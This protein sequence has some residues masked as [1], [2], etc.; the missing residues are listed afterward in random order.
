MEIGMR[1][2]MLR[3]EHDWKKTELARQLGISH[4]QVSR[5]ESGETETLSSDILIR[6][7]EVFDVST[8]YLLGLT[9]IKA[10]K[11]LDVVKL[12]L[13]EDAALRLAS[14]ALDMGMLSQLLEHEKFSNVLFLMRAFLDNSIE[15]G[16]RSRNDIIDLVTGTTEECVASLY[17]VKSREA[18]YDMK[19]LRAQKLCMHEAELEKIKGQFMSILRDI[20][21]KDKHEMPDRSIQISMIEKLRKECT[22]K[23]KSG[24]RMEAED[25]ALIT[26][27]QYKEVKQADDV[28]I[29]LFYLIMM[30]SM[31][32]ELAD[33]KLGIGDEGW[34]SLLQM[35]K[36]PVE[37]VG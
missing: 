30:R 16:N 3:E 27:K 15:M 11:N 1:I 36:L 31:L 12:G 29:V 9:P 35:E 28:T 37:L 17:P 7:A 19:I 34:S 26:A 25:V 5:I 10:R 22:A 6:L 23:L 4:S 21:E 20:K 33:E 32:G 18:K 8:D 24:K 14:G 2:A 13:S